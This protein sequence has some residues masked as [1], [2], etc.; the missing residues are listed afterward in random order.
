MLMDSTKLIVMY[1]MVI[2]LGWLCVIT[3]DVYIW[4]VPVER[5]RQIAREDFKSA[6]FL[7]PGKKQIKLWMLESSYFIWVSRIG[8][9]LMTGIMI[10]IT[11]FVIYR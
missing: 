9:V 8:S 5:R 4:F 10:A 7:F 11:L 3:W 1:W 2:G 6:K